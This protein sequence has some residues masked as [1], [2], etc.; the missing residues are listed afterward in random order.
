[1]FYPKE[2]TL[3]D[4]HVKLVCRKNMCIF[5]VD[6]HGIPLHLHPWRVGAVL[7]NGLIGTRS[8]CC[9]HTST[10][11][12]RMAPWD[13]DAYAVLPGKH[14]YRQSFWIIYYHLLARHDKN[15]SVWLRIE[16]QQWQPC[17]GCVRYWPSR[18]PVVLSSRW[19]EWCLFSPCWDMH[20]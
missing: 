7:P 19:P 13:S 5:N 15:E 10:W 4:E 8:Q 17:W 18:R 20:G 12:R 11:M 1:M 6:L 16:W 9:S 2:E 14:R 3:E